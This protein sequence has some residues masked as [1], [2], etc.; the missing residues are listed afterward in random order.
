MLYK[1]HHKTSYSHL[2][3]MKCQ[4][5]SNKGLPRANHLAFKPKGHF[6][7][8]FRCEKV[9]FTCVG[10]TLLFINQG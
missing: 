6:L 5:E 3:E 4:G 7:G 2:G 10:A 8:K 9:E 1:F